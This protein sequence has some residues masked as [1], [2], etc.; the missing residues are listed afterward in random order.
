MAKNQ[1]DGRRVL[2]LSRRHF[3]DPGG[4]QQAVFIYD[5]AW[6][7]LQALRRIL[8][9]DELLW[10]SDDHLRSSTGIVVQVKRVPR[11][12]QTTLR[13][14]L[15]YDPTLK[16]MSLE[17]S[18]NLRREC[19]IFREGRMSVEP[20]A[21]RRERGSSAPRAQAPAGYVHVSDIA[22]ALGIEP[23]VAR[24]ALRKIMTKPAVGWMWSPAEVED[25]KAK[26]REAIS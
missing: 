18:P 22:L 13:E 1:F 3:Q 6:E 12:L 11:G 5:T 23:R 21:P 25:V 19:R 20:A 2:Y 10:E 17:L 9:D 15:S 24:G 7:T 16:E 4:D 14:M 8:R 26:I